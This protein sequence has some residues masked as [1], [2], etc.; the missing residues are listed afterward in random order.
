MSE[1]H[2][3]A[4]P[5]G[6]TNRPWRRGESAVNDLSNFHST[7][8]CDCCASGFAFAQEDFSR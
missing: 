8:L 3:N 1:E 2:L 7:D 6:H 5:V 4:S